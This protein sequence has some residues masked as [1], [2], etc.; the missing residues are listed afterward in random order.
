MA[1]DT[2]TPEL[3]EQ[4]NQMLS[5]LVAQS[6]KNWKKVMQETL[7]E[8]EMELN[9]SKME[10]LL[11]E[12]DLEAPVGAVPGGTGIAK[13]EAGLE[14]EEGQLAIQLLKGAGRL[15]QCGRGRGKCLIVLSDEPLEAGTQTEEKKVATKKAT[16]KQAVAE[17]PTETEEVEEVEI[18]MVEANNI[19]ALLRAARDEYRRVKRDRDEAAR[20]VRDLERQCA[21]LNEVIAERE[22]T[23]RHLE[24]QVEQQA[25]ATWQ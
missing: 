12:H 4:A 17:A 9:V 18:D 6:K 7:S 25:V 2:L 23:I 16:K 20:T 19:P 3:A 11:A 22:A 1:N 15:Q 21:D 5:F 24:E 13:E 8:T 10:A 14:G